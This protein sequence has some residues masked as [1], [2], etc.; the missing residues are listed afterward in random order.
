MFVL[1]LLLEEYLSEKTS[2]ITLVGN[3]AE[4]DWLPTRQ[5]SFRHAREIAE[6]WDTGSFHINT[7]C[8][9]DILLPLLYLARRI[10]KVEEMVIN[11]PSL[12]PLTKNSFLLYLFY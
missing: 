11:S 10:I 3:K 1:S 8:R 7:R 12:N 4:D 9:T 5:I 6:Q 2:I